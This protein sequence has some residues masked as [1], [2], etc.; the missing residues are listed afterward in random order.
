MFLFHFFPSY[1][2]DSFVTSE[3]IILRD[4]L[5]GGTDCEYTFNLGPLRNTIRQAAEVRISLF[6][7]A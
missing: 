5:S 4:P 1:S 7:Y 3:S 6:Q 2:R